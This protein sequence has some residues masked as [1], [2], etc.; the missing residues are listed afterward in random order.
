MADIV[1]VIIQQL[2]PLIGL[3]LSIVGRAADMRMFQFGAI[4]SDDESTFGQYALHVQ[5]AW[6]IEGPDGIVTGRSDLWEPVEIGPEFDWDTWHYDKSENLQDRK[7][8][9]LLEDHEPRIQSTGLPISHL[10][11]ER[12][13]A[14]IYGGATI[15][16][17]GIYRLRIFPAGS[18]GEDWRMLEPGQQTPHFVIAGGKIEE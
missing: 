1:D 10:V 12:V 9:R 11:A 18:E 7:I 17:S 15:H 2:H 5:C 16:L 14:D 8:A 13:E 6:R 4:Q 3:P